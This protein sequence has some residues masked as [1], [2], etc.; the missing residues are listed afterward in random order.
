MNVTTNAVECLFPD[1]HHPGHKASHRFPVMIEER[2]V[3]ESLTEQEIVDKMRE[4]G[5]FVVG[6]KFDF[7]QEYVTDSDDLL[8]VCCERCGEGLRGGELAMV[9]DGLI[10]A[11][12]MRP[13]EEIA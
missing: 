12:C 2:G 7:W 1:M 5:F 10:H 8:A 4:G 9:D 11:A 3:W 13:G 6:S